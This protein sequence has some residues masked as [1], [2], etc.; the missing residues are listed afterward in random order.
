MKFLPDLFR[1][2]EGVNSSVEFC[3]SLRSR[4]NLKFDFINR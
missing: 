2:G 3:S 4:L 1:I